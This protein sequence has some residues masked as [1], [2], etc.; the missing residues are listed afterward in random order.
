MPI[1]RGRADPRIEFK[2]LVSALFSNGTSVASAQNPA[3]DRIVS[4]T[5]VACALGPTRHTQVMAC[6]VAAENLALLS[7]VSR[8]NMTRCLP[9]GTYMRIKEVMTQRA[10][11]GIKRVEADLMFRHM[12]WLVVHDSRS[13]AHIWQTG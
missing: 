7:I 13:G 4:L 6:L 12:K 10:Y 1:I 2:V 8:N 3:R 11:G 9:A 5:V